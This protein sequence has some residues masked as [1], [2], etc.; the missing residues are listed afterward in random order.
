MK[1]G[2]LG[3]TFD[4]PHIGHLIAAQDALQVLSLER[5]LL[6]PAARPPHKGDRVITPPALRLAMLR[7]AASADPRFGVDARELD[8]DGPSFTVETLREL[9]EGGDELVLLLGTDQYAEFETWREPREIQR[10]AGLGVMRRAGEL[11]QAQASSGAVY[12]VPVTRIDIS[13][14]QIRAAVA[15]GRSIRYLV[16]DAVAE[17]I[18]AHA[19]YRAPAGSPAAAA[20]APVRPSPEDRR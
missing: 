14:T 6:I 5:V 9:A 13:S 12:D 19:L 16:P 10:L 2:L 8:R 4:P 7:L 3:G 15:E 20:G 17:Y 11:V 18:D 1:L